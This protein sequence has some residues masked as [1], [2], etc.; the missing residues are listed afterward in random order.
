VCISRCPLDY[1][2]P[3]GRI[4]KIGLL[5]RPASD[6]AGR[7]GS[8]VMNPGGPGGSGMSVATYLAGKIKDNEVGRRF[9]LAGL[10]QRVSVPANHKLSAK[11]QRNGRRTPDGPWSRH[12]A[13]R[14]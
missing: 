10:D 3:S 9:D 2:N 8:L 4:I 14:G 13:G 6:P 1:A 7:I 5:R 11:L 12:L